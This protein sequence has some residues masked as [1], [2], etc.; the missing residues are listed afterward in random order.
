MRLRTPLVVLLL[1][2]SIIVLAQ[3]IVERPAI[4]RVGAW[5][6]IGPEGAVVLGFA[7]DPSRPGTVY[8]ATSRRL[9]RSIDDG[10]TWG[11]D[12][13]IPGF[14]ATGIAL[15]PGDEPVLFVTDRYEGLLRS[16]D[17][18]RSWMSFQLGG[19]IGIGV[20]VDPNAPDRVWAAVS[21]GIWRSTDRGETWEVMGLPGGQAVL[22]DRTDG[23]RVFAGT[24]LGLFR[25]LDS[26]SSWQKVSDNSVNGLTQDPAREG[27][28]FGWRSDN[29]SSEIAQSTDDGDSWSATNKPSGF[30]R[31]LALD[32]TGVVYATTDFG[33]SLSR[34]GG[35]TWT[36]VPT[37]PGPGAAVFADGSRPEVVYA[38]AGLSVHR[39]RDGG[40]TFSSSARGL[41]NPGS[42]WVALNPRDPRHVLGGASSATLGAGFPST[43]SSRDGG[44]TW[45]RSEPG[46]VSSFAVD[47]ERPERVYAAGGSGVFRSDDGG[48]T[49]TRSSTGLDYPVT[50]ILQDPLDPATFYV[51]SCCGPNGHAGGVYKSSDSGATW[52]QK[53]GGFPS[54][55]TDPEDLRVNSLAANPLTGAIYAASDFGIMRSLNHGESWIRLGLR[56]TGFVAVDPV[57]PETVYVIGMDDESSGL[58]RSDDGGTFWSHLDGV[59]VRSVVPDPST[60]GV[61]YATTLDRGVLRSADRGVTWESWNDGL[62]DLCVASIAID[63][64]GQTLVAGTCSNGVYER[65]VR[66]PRKT[67]VVT[68]GPN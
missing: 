65:S 31:G 53:A 5:R 40:A 60:S 18:G 4:P 56:E 64:S 41:V 24:T 42:Y 14:S 11:S 8:A 44:S 20:T 58:F 12:Q 66:R 57:S 55:P 59:S 3:A 15:S 54:N 45:T 50:A 32:A 62:R 30:I 61:L 23:N 6:S 9:Y 34:D 48:T 43:Y 16:A 67:E 52:T 27:V 49:W 35:S 21:D 25:S 63:A 33:L 29:Y 1:S 19:D 68:R 13:A 36:A 51:G 22:V 17:G 37:E 2:S 7:V 10:V 38:G 26:G 47:S 39:T 28:F 46:D